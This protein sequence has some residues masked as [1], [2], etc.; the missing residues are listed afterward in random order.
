MQYFAYG[1]NMDIAQ[2]AVRCHKATLRG[3]GLLAGY[4][5]RIDGRG[6]ATVDQDQS[7]SVLGL[8]WEL[9]QEDEANL[10]RYEGVPRF[11]TKQILEIGHG[12]QRTPM[13]IYVSTDRLKGKPEPS[14]LER[15]VLAAQVQG[16]REAYVD[17]L[18]SW[19]KNIRA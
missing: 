14:Y 2:M 6:F 18:K 1:S 8:V 19:G 15:I 7:A 11:Y 12:E 17:E 13:L 10:D 3:T 4:R 5:F 16:F 9:S